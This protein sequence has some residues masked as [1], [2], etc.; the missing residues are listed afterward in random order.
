MIKNEGFHFNLMQYEDKIR[1]FLQRVVRTD[2]RWSGSTRCRCTTWGMP[3]QSS[4]CCMASR[5]LSTGLVWSHWSQSG[6]RPDAQQTGSQLRIHDTVQKH[7][8]LFSRVTASCSTLWKTKPLA[9]SERLFSSYLCIFRPLMVHK[10]SKY[11]KNVNTK[12]L[13][14][15]FSP[16]FTLRR[17]ILHSPSPSSLNT[18]LYS[19]PSSAHHPQDVLTLCISWIS[20]AK[21]I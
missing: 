3:S 1:L 9:E 6:H 15:H 18:P 4:A 20:L 7:S 14:L 8:D 11:S 13:H 2:W 17:F 10:Y 5:A 19:N 21:K 12:L 16:S